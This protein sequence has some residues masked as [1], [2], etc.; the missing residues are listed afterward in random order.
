MN[1]EILQEEKKNL[2]SCL[3][4]YIFKPEKKKIKKFYGSAERKSKAKQSKAKQSKIKQTNKK[5]NCKK[6][7]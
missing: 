3:D 1:V 7:K 5:I 6:A 4:S 2:L